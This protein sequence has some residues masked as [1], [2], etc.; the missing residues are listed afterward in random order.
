M[1]EYRRNL[2]FSVTM[3]FIH[4]I[5]LVSAVVIQQGAESCYQ[6]CSA[7]FNH[8]IQLL[9]GVTDTNVLAQRSCLAMSEHMVCLEQEREK[10]DYNSQQHVNSI[11]NFMTPDYERR[12]SSYVSPSVSETPS[13]LI[14][15]QCRNKAQGCYLTFNTTF[16]PAS[17][18]DDWATACDSL[19]NYTLCVEDIMPECGQ[20]LTQFISHIRAKQ[21]D[22]TA[23][24]SESSSPL[25]H[26]EC[27]NDTLDCY[28]AFSN[29]F[30]PANKQYLLE[31]MCS[32]MDLYT[33]CLH[34]VDKRQQCR[35]F[36]QHALSSLVTFKSSFAIYC[37]TDGGQH[38][39]TCV[40]DFQQCYSRFNTTYFPAL[41][42]GSMQGICSSVMHY[43]RCVQP[44]YTDC[45]LQMSHALGS[46]RVL[47]EQFAL[48]CDPEFQR[49]S[50]CI[51]LGTCLVKF[52]EGMSS[53]PTSS[54]SAQ[55]CKRLSAYFPCVESSMAQCSIPP[56]DTSVD[57][58]RL[59]A[60][61]GAY[62]THLLGN[63][64]LNSCEEFKTCAG[65][66]VLV[67]SP[68][69]SAMFDADTWCSYIDMSLSCVQRA[70]NT[71]SCG[72][73]Q[74]DTII[75]H[76]TQ[77][78]DLKRDICK[79]A[80][81]PPIETAPKDSSS[82]GDHGHGH[83]K[84]SGAD[85]IMTPAEVMSLVGLTVVSLVYQRLF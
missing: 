73:G 33:L 77:Q 63:A 66:I 3:V 85:A 67:S 54:S 48:Q 21:R 16:Y 45:G 29:T 56:E 41:H 35:R 51:P 32:A 27:V 69:P 19:D 18:L 36:S 26:T 12:C 53:E 59:G 80:S 40:R 8:R 81:V 23:N 47:K 22:H 5:V 65:G 39:Q 28:D 13:G 83:Q 9:K 2:F 7:T 57:F 6:H 60:L 79:M 1:Q 46:V 72:L 15:S 49:L 64:V 71:A 10:C 55:F 74:A 43:S 78:R 84:H 82:S 76:L 62:C 37:A 44:L 30:I 4:L 61:L 58:S 50:S 25:A 11:L 52:S 38:A 17:S 68:D 31:E 75:G 14:A 42:M 20:H 70:V 24:C 34:G